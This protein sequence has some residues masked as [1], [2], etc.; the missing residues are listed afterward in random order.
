MKSEMDHS[1]LRFKVRDQ[2]N[3]KNGGDNHDCSG[4]LKWGHFHVER[5]HRSR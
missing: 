2:Q 4:N 5:R 1:P 3:N